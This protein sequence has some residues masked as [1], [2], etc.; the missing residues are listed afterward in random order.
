MNVPGWIVSVAPSA[1][2]R[3]EVT[4]TVSAVHVESVDM[5]SPTSILCEKHG[6]VIKKAM[7]A[8]VRILFIGG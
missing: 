3:S 2:V 4:F 5:V 7:T 8:V 6:V 1:T